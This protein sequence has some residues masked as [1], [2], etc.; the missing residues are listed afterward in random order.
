[1][2][3]VIITGNTLTLEE[4]MSVCRNFTKVELSDLAV[5]KVL[6]SRKIVDDFVENKF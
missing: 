6:K 5:E 2:E 1:M 4:V 3:K